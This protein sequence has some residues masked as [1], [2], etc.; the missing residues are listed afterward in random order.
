MSVKAFQVHKLSEELEL[1]K[2]KLE[3][4][5][6]DKEESLEN[7]EGVDHPNAQRVET[8]SEQVSI[9]DDALSSLEDCISALQDYL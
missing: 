8:L 2:E 6:D 7:A 1:L 9:L 4:F 3:S 5:R